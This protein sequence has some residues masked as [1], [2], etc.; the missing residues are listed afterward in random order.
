MYSP[1]QK[2]ISLI[3]LIILS[4]LFVL[5]SIIILFTDGFPII[6]SQ[7]RLGMNGL[8]FK[9]LKFRSMKKN[10]E[11]I[12]IKDKKLMEIYLSN[13]YKIPQ[14][15]ET[16]YTKIG[17]LLRK[18][19]LDELPQLFNV[20]MGTMNLVGPRPIVPNEVKFYE[21]VKKDLFLSIRPGVT[22]SWQ[23][24]GRSE[25]DYPER[26]D[27]EL[28]YIK[29]R[30]TILDIKILFKTLFVVLARKGAHWSD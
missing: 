1:F 3:L 9:C 25:I 13:D 27:F 24:S 30:S 8:K 11:E 26:V 19:S 21:G 28:E 16:R 18:T 5:V 7:E 4:P 15:Y 20:L 14:E 22:G 12:L 23:V 29:N 6:F 2:I 17:L 10:A